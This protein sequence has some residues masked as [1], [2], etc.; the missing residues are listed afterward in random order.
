[1]P[2]FL[3]VLMFYQ[4]LILGCCSSTK[5]GSVVVHLVIGNGL[6]YSQSLEETLRESDT[7]KNLNSRANLK[8]PQCKECD[9]QVTGTGCVCLMSCC[10]SCQIQMGASQLSLLGGSVATGSDLKGRLKEASCS[11]GPVDAVCIS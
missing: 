10:S 8:L 1:M 6:R 7:K 3:Q 9:T 4:L 2:L 5:R 11:R